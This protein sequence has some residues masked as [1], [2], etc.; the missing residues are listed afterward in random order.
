MINAATG[1]AVTCDINLAI[2]KLGLSHCEYSL[3]QSI[4]PHHITEWRGDPDNSGSVNCPS[5]EDLNNAWYSIPDTSYI[6]NR[7]GITTTDGYATIGDQLDQLYHDMTDGKL[8]VAATTSSWYV[9]ITSVKV[10]YPK[11]S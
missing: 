2:Q 1:I 11:P 4:P 8:G 10:K 9:G 7:V 5:A 6:S 3:N